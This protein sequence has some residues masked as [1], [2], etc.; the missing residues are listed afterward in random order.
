MELFLACILT[1]A[2]LFATRLCVTN[3]CAIVLYLYRI[4][5]KIS[6]ASTSL[7]ETQ[8]DF[9]SKEVLG[10]I[11]LQLAIRRPRYLTPLKAR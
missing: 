5:H 11:M 6:S 2:T 7:P 10:L 9:N 3:I 1:Y 4:L 8:F